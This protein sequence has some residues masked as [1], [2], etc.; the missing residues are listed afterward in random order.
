MS[1]IFIAGE[2]T[3]AELY[4]AVDEADDE[5]RGV[6]I[7]TA[8]AFSEG[9]STLIGCYLPNP[10]TIGNTLVMAVMPDKNS[11]AFTQPVGWSILAQ[12]VD[13]VD[14]DM[15]YEVYYKISDGTENYISGAWTNSTRSAISVVEF[16][17][18]YTFDVVSQGSSGAT[19]QNALS[20][21][22]TMGLATTSSLIYTM[23]CVDSGV[24]VDSTSSWSN[25]INIVHEI[26]KITTP[27]L[28]SAPAM[29]IGSKLVTAQTGVESTYTF[30]GSGT[31]QM[32]AVIIA[33]KE[34]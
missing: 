10:P 18:G 20:T 12:L 32:R 25:D 4:I 7:Q 29:S 28:S 23:A 22:T 30:T 9:S 5:S 27:D 6:V 8:K 31:D 16:Q 34:I 13:S 1:E 11:G 33:F 3:M 26:N 19:A 21:G 24:Y 2:D 17:G 15:S 14:A